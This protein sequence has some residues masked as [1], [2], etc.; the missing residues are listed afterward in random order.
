MRKEYLYHRQIRSVSLILTVD[1][2][3]IISFIEGVCI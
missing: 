2:E 3:H 1:Q